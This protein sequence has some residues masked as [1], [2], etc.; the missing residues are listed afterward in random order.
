MVDLPAPE[1]PVIKAVANGLRQK[2][3]L[4][5]CSPRTGCRLGMRIPGAAKIGLREQTRQL[6]DAIAVIG[7]NQVRLGFHRRQRVVDRDS[8]TAGAQERLV[9]LGIADAHHIVQR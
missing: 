4:S 1:D 9:V 6:D 3:V 7:N 2:G 8:A 5:A